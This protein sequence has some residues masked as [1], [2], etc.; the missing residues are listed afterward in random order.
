MSTKARNNQPV[1]MLYAS[2]VIA[3]LAG[4]DGTAQN[5]ETALAPEMPR[6]N[7][8]HLIAGRSTW[9]GT[10]RNCH[11]MGVSGAPSVTDYAAWEARLGKG[12]LALY[13]SAL[14]GVRD[15]GGEVRM[16]PRGGNSRLTDEQVKRAVDYMVASVRRFKQN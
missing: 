16:P 12:E 7:E 10:C 5:S 9:M 11:L 15:S 1:R 13:R 14:Q 3:A 6:F 4:C 8:T 2:C